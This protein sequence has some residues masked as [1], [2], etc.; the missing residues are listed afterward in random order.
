MVCFPTYCC[1]QLVILALQVTQSLKVGHLPFPL[2]RL[3]SLIRIPNKKKKCISSNNTLYSD[4]FHSGRLDHGFGP[5]FSEYTLVINGICPPIILVPPSLTLSGP[6]LTTLDK[7]QNQATYGTF[8]LI[9][10]V[11][12]IYSSKVS[13][14]IPTS[15]LFTP[16]LTLFKIYLKETKILVSFTDN[17]NT[18]CL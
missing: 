7:P 16:T 10:L 11:P 4:I 9:I 12:T 18:V 6:S 8:C 15:L 14:P 1:Q 3:I 5:V 2:C 13:F 17:T